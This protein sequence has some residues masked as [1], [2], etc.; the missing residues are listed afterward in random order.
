MLQPKIETNIRIFPNPNILQAKHP[1]Q[2]RTSGQGGLE[3]LLHG[4]EC[5]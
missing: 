1:F 2:I 5:A 4:M 3:E